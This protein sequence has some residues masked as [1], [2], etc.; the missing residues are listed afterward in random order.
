MNTDTPL[1]IVITGLQ[2]EL[3]TDQSRIVAVI[4]FTPDNRLIVSAADEITAAR[5]LTGINVPVL[6]TGSTV[7]EEDGEQGTILRLVKTL[8][9]TGA[10]FNS[11]G[12]TSHGTSILEHLGFTIIQKYILQVPLPSFSYHF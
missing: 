3:I 9:G 2:R 12:H 1:R 4:H 5:I 8:P 11:L 10:H 7:F 6:G